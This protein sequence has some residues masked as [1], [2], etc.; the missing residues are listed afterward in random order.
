MDCRMGQAR[1]AAAGRGMKRSGK[2]HVELLRRERSSTDTSSVSLDDTDDLSNSLGRE[3]E[4]SA[5]SSNAG[6]GRSDEG[7]STKVEVEHQGVGAFD[8]DALLGEEGFVEE[9]RAVDDVGLETS[10][11]LLVAED[12]AFSVVP[13]AREGGGGEDRQEKVSD[14]V[15]IEQRRVGS[16]ASRDQNSLEVTVTLDPSLN[17]SPEL[18]GES[19]LIEEMVNTETRA[20]SLGGVS[21][22]D[23]LLG[24][25]NRRSAEL[26]FL[27]SIDD[28]VEVEDEVSAV[29]E[30][31]TAVAVEA[32]S[33]ARERAKQGETT[34]Q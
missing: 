28:L 30:E 5:N 34:C 18:L 20:G 27:E 2:T 24:S 23:S 11:E 10:G 15:R 25:T 9:G 32:C 31:K 29:G 17:K 1:L 7:V 33:E 22:A 21:W 14:R 26:G 19:L 4:S 6:R 8:E 13:V 12:L 3:S 16:S